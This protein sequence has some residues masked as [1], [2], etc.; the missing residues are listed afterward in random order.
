VPRPKLASI[1]VRTTLAAAAAAAVCFGSG[2][3]WLRHELYADRFEASVAL[4]A[5]DVRDLA[6]A[7][8][9]GNTERMTAW[10]QD[11]DWVALDGANRVRADHSRQIVDPARWRAA[12][13]A[14]PNGVHLAEIDGV[15]FAEADVWT[16]TDGRV[17][18]D[19]PYLSDVVTGVYVDPAVAGTR[20]TYFMRV[21][22]ADAGSAVDPLLVL[23]LPAAV[24]LVA[25]V[26]W[27]TA[28]RTLKPVERIVRA[29]S[30]ELATITSARL[31]HRVPVPDTGDEIEALALTTN[32]MLGR[33]QETVD[34]QRRFITDA[35]HELRSP[36][37]GL[38]NTIEVAR[39]HPDRPAALD[40][41]LS[42]AVRLQTLTDDLLLLARSGPHPST[43]VDLA[44]IAEEQV[45]E[46][47]GGEV[48][49]TASLTGPAL[50]TGDQLQLE[51]LVRN[52]LDNA[53]R[54]AAGAVTV[55][56][57]AAPAGIVVEVTDDGEGIAPAD[58]E[59][60]FEPFTRLDDARTRDSGG[61]GLG[62][63]IVHDIATRHGARV[64]VDNAP[65]ARF[66]VRFP[67]PL[68]A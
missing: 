67:T 53:A 21:S 31:D 20:V 33:L 4:A 40:V 51:R 22:P 57:S 17:T 49:F 7:D 29:V 10:Y 65:G 19:P 46:R 61:T 35:A 59:R 15:T 8:A 43:P 62:L 6:V 37:A 26:A 39:A 27:F 54:H 28:G 11:A 14:Q 48:T 23:G 2:A 34:R 45:A 5:S 52:L 56:V 55:T 13:H 24:L 63:A 64:H 38:R 66:T 58:R 30:D 9:S 44:A 18:L 3:L 68:P 1:R 42:S 41:V 16:G 60:V 36:L 32:T 12:G 50:V 47:Q 25:A